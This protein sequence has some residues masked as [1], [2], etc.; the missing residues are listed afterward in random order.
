MRSSIREFW[1]RLDH[2]VHPDDASV[3][4]SQP[5]TFNLDFPP[6]AFI[7]DVDGAPIV[8]LMANG[9]YDPHPT[10]GTRS[11]FLEPSDYKEHLEMLG[12]EGARMP[13]RLS[14]YYTQNTAFRWV[15]EGKAVIVNAVAYRSRKI[16]EEPQNRKMVELL[17]SVGVHRHWLHE[18]VLPDAM[19]GRR[20]VVA[21]RWSLWKLSRSGAPLRNVHFSENPVSPYLAH[22]LM[23]RLDAW[24]ERHGW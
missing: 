23:N 4:A 17:P 2:A 12:R 10:T 16:S 13:R 14:P 7:G 6:P 18:E 11:E 19:G 21:H 22:D 5:H 1:R 9:G 20:C 3:L 15:R 24:L 8:I